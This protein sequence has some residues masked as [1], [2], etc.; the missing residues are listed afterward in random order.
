MQDFAVDLGVH[1]HLVEG[2]EL[3]LGRGGSAGHGGDERDSERC[4]HLVSFGSSKINYKH[5][6]VAL[7]SFNHSLPYLS[8][9]LKISIKLQDGRSQG[10]GE[11]IS[12]SQGV[13]GSRT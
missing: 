5:R 3:L 4:F 9:I 6:T 13:Y 8:S 11:S 10:T 7:E 12:T 1:D 2:R